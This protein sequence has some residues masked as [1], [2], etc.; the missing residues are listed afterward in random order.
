MASTEVQMISAESLSGAHVLSKDV[1][2]PDIAT[3]LVLEVGGVAVIAQAAANLERLGYKQELKRRMGFSH[4]LGMLVS[5]LATP[6]ALG[7]TMYNAI[8]GGGPA[9]MIWGCVVVFLVYWCIA[10]ALGELVSKFPTSA[11]LY[12]WTFTLAPP[13]YRALLSYIVGWLIVIA[14]LLAALSVSF[15]L[16]TLLVGTIN[17]VKPDWAPAQ[18]VYVLITWATLVCSAMP[19]LHT[20]KWVPLMDL[21]NAIF[22]VVFQVV[23]IV[24]ICVRAKEG[25]RSPSYAFFHFDPSFSG[26]N[27]GWTFFL[28]ILPPAFSIAS[29]GMTTGMA[30]EILQPEKNLPRAMIWTLPISLVLEWMFYLPLVFTMPD[31][32]K[33]LNAPNGNIL[34]YMLKLIIGDDSGAIFIMVCILITVYFCA[35]AGNQAASRLVWAFARD[36]AVPGWKYWSRVGANDNINNAIYLTFAVQAAVV[37][38]D[39]GSTLAYNTF[40]GVAIVAYTMSYVIPVVVSL[41]AGRKAVSTAPFGA[42]FR[43]IG[44]FTNYMTV[45]WTLFAMVLFCSPVT[46]PATVAGM[47]YASVVLLGFTTVFTLWYFLSAR[48]VYVGPPVG[49]INQELRENAV[50]E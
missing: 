36:K 5:L 23:F 48:G 28:G 3:D 34:P 18:W 1:K 13:R 37:L 30:E 44:K 9:P 2:A 20:P 19:L 43:F 15:G 49:E 50:A 21:S 41:L 10:Y 39:L 31:P 40:I 22:S 47:N 38:I 17:I 32:E 7:S 25:Y 27:A 24:V 35:V 33:L 46:L 11:G 29:I 16:A 45:A 14:S 8:I 42:K 6:F 12:Y 4:M 26:W